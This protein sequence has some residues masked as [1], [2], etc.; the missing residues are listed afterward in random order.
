MTSTYKSYCIACRKSCKEDPIDMNAEKGVYVYTHSETQRQHTRD[1]R[2]YVTWKVQ[3]REKLSPLRGC[4]HP[5]RES[6]FLLHVCACLFACM[7]IWAP[8]TCLVPTEAK[9]VRKIP[10]NWSYRWLWATMRVLGTEPRSSGKEARAFN[11]WVISPA[12]SFQSH[13][14]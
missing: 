3:A 10:W 4:E 8:S 6:E 9:R 5:A 11:G 12:L 13:T 1:N 7:C 14:T 2:W